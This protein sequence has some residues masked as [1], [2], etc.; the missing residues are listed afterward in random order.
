[1]C[2]VAF[3]SMV[4]W[5][6]LLYIKWGESLF[7]GKNSDVKR[8]W[9]RAILGWVNVKRAWF[10]SILGWVTDRK[11]LLGYARVRTICSVFR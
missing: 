3:V 2:G 8:V 4:V 6:S 10:R 11:V 1:M 7:L 5:W 9:L